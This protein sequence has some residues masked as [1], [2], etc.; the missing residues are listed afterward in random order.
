MSDL[1]QAIQ[2]MGRTL[3]ALRLEV[4]PEV[5]DDVTARWTDLLTAIKYRLNDMED[6][7]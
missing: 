2:A 5:A 1:Q 7:R 6:L 4:P 3:H